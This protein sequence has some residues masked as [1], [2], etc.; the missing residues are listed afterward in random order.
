M[1]LKNLIASTAIAAQIFIGGTSA[2]DISE[3]LNKNKKD[4]GVP[5]WIR[6]DFKESGNYSAFTSCIPHDLEDFLSKSCRAE[7]RFGFGL[8]YT[9]KSNSANLTGDVECYIGQFNIKFIPKS[10]TQGIINPFI[11]IPFASTENGGMPTYEVDCPPDTVWNAYRKVKMGESLKGFIKDYEAQKRKEL[12]CIRCGVTAY[13]LST[14][15]YYEISTDRTKAKF[16]IN[17]E[18]KTK[19]DDYGHF[20]Y[21]HLSLEVEVMYNKT[22]NRWHSPKIINRYRDP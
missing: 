7:A 2:G 17:C 10:T 15:P 14:S 16:K 18:Y 6:D 13:L 8:Y 1:G 20:D 4:T 5:V 11:R 3:V 19:E 9:P 12:S 22:G 21:K